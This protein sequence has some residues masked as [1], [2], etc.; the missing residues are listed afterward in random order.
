MAQTKHPL[1]DL[2]SNM[3]RATKLV[4]L[5]PTCA[6]WHVTEQLD[7]I[8]P[9]GRCSSY[10]TTFPFSFCLKY[11]RNIS[12]HVSSRAPAHEYRNA[13]YCWLNDSVPHITSHNLYKTGKPPQRLR[14]RL[15]FE[16]MG[17]TK[18]HSSTSQKISTLRST[19]HS[20]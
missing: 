3:G 12:M 14:A 4:H 6:C 7:L 10:S 9:V 5:P 18:R 20:K 16:M 19:K 2:G 13:S 17:T 11:L 1:L 15:S 8:I